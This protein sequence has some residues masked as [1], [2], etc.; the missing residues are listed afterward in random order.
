MKIGDIVKLIAEPQVDWMFDYLEKT[1][2]VL[3]FPTETGVEVMMVGS[4][5]EWVWIISKVNLEV[6]GETG[7][8]CGDST[9]S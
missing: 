1:F 3:D 9:E 8:H 4:R 6:T 7:G 5:P 2:Q